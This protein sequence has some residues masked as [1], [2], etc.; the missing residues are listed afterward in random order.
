MTHNTSLYMQLQQGRRQVQVGWLAGG[1]VGVAGAEAGVMGRGPHHPCNPGRIL[2]ET[3]IWPSQTC[4]RYGPDR[5]Q[6]RVI[7][8]WPGG[9]KGISHR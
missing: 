1:E 2:M 3:V 4:C 8:H 6:M 7:L 9:T 5:A